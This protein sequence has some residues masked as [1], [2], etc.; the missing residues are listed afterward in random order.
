MRGDLDPCLD[1]T[2]RWAINAS[3]CSETDPE[4][5]MMRRMLTTHRADHHI[6]DRGRG[7][8]PGCAAASPDE[9]TGEI[10]ECRPWDRLFRRLAPGPSPAHV[11]LVASAIA[12]VVTAIRTASRHDSFDLMLVLHPVSRTVAP[13]WRRGA[14]GPWRPAAWARSVPTWVRG[15]CRCGMSP[16]SQA[17]TSCSGPARAAGWLDHLRDIEERSYRNFGDISSEPGPR[18]RPSAQPASWRA[19]EPGPIVESGRTEVDR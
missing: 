4:C 3:G 2:R 19:P 12:T 6:V 7:F 15:F 8:S 18:R 17:G 14:V 1:L 5:S 9:L 10:Q 13:A 16:T 11:A